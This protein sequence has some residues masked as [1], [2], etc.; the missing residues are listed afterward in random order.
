MGSIEFWGFFWGGG[1]LNAQLKQWLK[2][3]LAAM[4]LHLSF[5]LLCR[6]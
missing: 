5:Y 3:L 1:Y 6:A 2:I 4:A